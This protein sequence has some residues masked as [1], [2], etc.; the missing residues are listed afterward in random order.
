MSEMFSW[1]SFNG[2]IANWDVSA[3]KDMSQMFAY[4]S[5]T[6]DISKWDVSAVNDMSGMFWASSFN[7]D[8][9]LWDISNVTDMSSMFWDA[10]AFHRSL[11]AWSNSTADMANMFG[12]TS[13]KTGL[14][15]SSGTYADGNMC[16]VPCPAQATCAGEPALPQCA[17]GYMLQANGDR[18]VCVASSGCIA[19]FSPE[20]ANSM[21]C[22][23]E[24]YRSANCQVPSSL[25]PSSGGIPPA[26][27]GRA[28]T[29]WRHNALV[30]TRCAALFTDVAFVPPPS[31]LPSP[32]RVAG[33]QDVGTA[34]FGI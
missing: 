24:P 9:S 5:F 12:G 22:V 15:C 13:P 3:V 11:C 1:S 34:V 28:M 2:N 25:S 16:C 14:C 8:L 32:M 17:G 18:V 10:I 27:S 20:D 29:C 23:K 21:A 33:G 4:S 19:Q 26:I 31:W 6:G 30:R 7:A